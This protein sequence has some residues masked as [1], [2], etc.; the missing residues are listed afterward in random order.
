M[1]GCVSPK[2][3]ATVAGRAIGVLLDDGELEEIAVG[4]LRIGARH[5]EQIAKAKQ[6]WLRIGPLGCAGR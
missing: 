3:N 4:W 2:I 6:E 5:V 1:V